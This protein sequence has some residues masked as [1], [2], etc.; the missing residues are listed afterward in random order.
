VGRL[1][2]DP[3]RAKETR[4]WDDQQ[5]VDRDVQAAAWAALGSFGRAPSDAQ[6]R[7]RRA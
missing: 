4:K 1:K 3:E 5:P 2:H 6:M 7:R